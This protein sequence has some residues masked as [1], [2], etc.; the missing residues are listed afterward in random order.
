MGSFWCELLKKGVIQ[1]AKMQ[2]QAKIYKFHTKIAAKLLNFS[3]CVRSAQNLY[4]KFDTK[5]DKGVTGC[6]LKK[7]WGYWV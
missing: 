2:C 5:V 6:G 7:T 4:V 3:K 1:C